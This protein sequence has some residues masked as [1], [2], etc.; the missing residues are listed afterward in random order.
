MS[1]KIYDYVFY[2]SKTQINPDFSQ[3]YECKLAINDKICYRCGCEVNSDSCSECAELGELSKGD[4]LYRLPGPIPISEYRDQLS[5]LNLTSLQKEASDFI[6][7]NVKQSTNCLIWAVCGAGKTE[8]SFQAIEYVL[9]QRK[10]VCFCIPRIDILYEIAER[11][12]LFFPNTVVSIVNGK[13]KQRDDTQIFVMTTNQLLKCKNVFDLILVD[14]VDAFPFSYHP[15]FLY[16]VRTALTDKG[17]F[18]CL[19]STPSAMIKKLELNTFMI[20]KRWHNFPLPVPKTH[21]WMIN[22]RIIFFFIFK[23]LFRNIKQQQLIF[24]CNKVGCEQLALFLQQ[25]LKSYCINFVHSQ[26]PKRRSVVEAFSRGEIDI[27]ITTPILERGVTFKD[28]DVYILDAD[29]PL[30]D[31]ASLVQIAG[32]C[33]RHPDFQDGE[34]HFYYHQYTDAIK[35]AIKQIKMMNKKA[36]KNQA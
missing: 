36:K 20:Y 10:L 13:E 19:T 27:L 25:N 16:G 21:M 31:V 32:R 18:C 33:G 12:Q 7:S 30:Y 17:S 34:V 14:E 15:K 1:K 9:T 22:N 29:N 6:I 2:V 3:A 23:H 8:I 28:I 4:Y 26:H 5:N 11:L 35:A 24:V